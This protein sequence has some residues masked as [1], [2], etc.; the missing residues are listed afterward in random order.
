MSPR[1]SNERRKKNSISVPS[2]KGYATNLISC[3]WFGYTCRYCVCACVCLSCQ[4]QEADVCIWNAKMSHIFL[5]PS[6]WNDVWLF[7]IN[8]A[9]A[10]IR[11]KKRDRNKTM[12]VHRL[13]MSE[14]LTVAV[15]IIL[16]LFI[17]RNCSHLSGSF[18]S[19]KFFRSNHRVDRSNDSERHFDFRAGNVALQKIPI[20][21]WCGSSPVIFVTSHTW[22]HPN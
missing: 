2:T 5:E 10:Q 13:H 15:S 21:V 14:W 22:T 19:S 9:T 7:I 16:H 1:N 11:K 4:S 8:E 18:L 12:N 20:I 6:M 17:L 3:H